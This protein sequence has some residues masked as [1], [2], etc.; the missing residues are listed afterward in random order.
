MVTNTDDGYRI[1]TKRIT[2]ILFGSLLIG[3]G[4]TVVAQTYPVKPIR[5]IVPFPPGG[6]ADVFSRVIG[7]KL[8][9]AWGQAVIV[10]NRPGAG[11]NIGAEAVAK[12]PPDGYTL[13]I[14]SIG[15][16]AANWSLF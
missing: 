14:G 15:T 9:D 3:L 1:G 6:I 8:N 2:I 4:H 16:H 12:A 11:G 5:F 10:E 13:G 7:Q